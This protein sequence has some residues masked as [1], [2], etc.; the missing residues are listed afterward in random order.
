MICII[1][2]S[3]SGKSTVEEILCD[4]FGFEK[5]VSYTTRPMRQGEVDGKAYHFITEEE[6]KKLESENF[7]VETTVFR[8]W[9]Y[10]AAKQD[11]VDNSVFVIEPIGLRKLIEQSEELNLSLKIF[12]IITNE[13]VRMMR[14]CK[15]GD[16]A[17]EIIRRIQ[18]DRET[19]KGAKDL[20]TVTLDGEL[21]PTALALKIVKHCI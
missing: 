9:H 19:F 11:C 16:D 15:R 14:M 17:D 20:A 2:E 12:Y 18:A 6:F 1:G 7:F 4:K 3:G 13:R 8:D 10:G 5:V 21:H